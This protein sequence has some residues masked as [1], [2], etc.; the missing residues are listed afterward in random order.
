MSDAPHPPRFLSLRK[1]AKEY[2]QGDAPLKVLK[3]VTLQVREGEA[4]MIVGPSGAGKSTLLHI[5]GLLDT[6]TSG[7]VRFKDDDLTALPARKRARLR[8]TLFGFVFQFFHLL[9]DF[10]ALENVIMPAMVGSTALGWPGRK[11]AVHERA[12]QLLDRVGL[13]DR[14]THRPTQLSGG[15]RQRVAIC[16]ALINRPPI[17][18]LDEPTGNVDSQTGREIL[19]LI[20]DLNAREGQTLVM[21]T[22][23]PEATER[24]GRVIHM[25]DGHLH[26]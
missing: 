15:E 25:R 21:V 9:P 20:H 6:P 16:R 12:R 19:D 4:L 17:L 18:L 24:A 13:S 1:V 2:P 11:R 5:L 10:N 7:Q 22:H 26:E 23:D 3:G 8:N 14:V